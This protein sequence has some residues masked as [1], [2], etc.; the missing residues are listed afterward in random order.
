MNG[1]RLE[2]LLTNIVN[3]PVMEYWQDVGCSTCGFEHAG[4]YI[5]YVSR[6]PVSPAKQAELEQTMICERCSVLHHTGKMEGPLVC[7][8]C[9]GRLVEIPTDPEPAPPAP[10]PAPRPPKFLARIALLIRGGSTD[11]E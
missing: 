2:R 1:P 10:A 8:Q 9:G 6:A 7:E 4:E 3:Q 5:S 11:D